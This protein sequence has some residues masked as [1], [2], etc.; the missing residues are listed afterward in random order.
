MCYIGRQRHLSEPVQDLLE[1][2][3]KF[4]THQA[5]AA[6]HD[7]QDLS[8]QAP[9]AEYCPGAGPEL[10]AWPHEA[11]PDILFHAL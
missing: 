3:L 9:V 6:L 11:L 2:P 4:K 5:V 10:F 7:L 1:N 8:L